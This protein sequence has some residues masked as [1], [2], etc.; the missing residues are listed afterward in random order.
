M[1]TISE[2]AKHKNCSRQTVYNNLRNLDFVKQYGKI[3]IKETDNNNNWK[4]EESKK[5]KM[6]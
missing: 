1:K 2:F 3:L 5:R 4:P 6:K